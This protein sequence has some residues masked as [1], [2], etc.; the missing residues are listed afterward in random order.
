MTT[1][2]PLTLGTAGHIDH[3][4][5]ALVAA[6]TGG[7]T[8]RLPAEKAR[9]ISIELGYAP[10]RLAS[11]RRLSVVDVP[12]HERF[13][14][15]MVAGATGID[16]YLMVVAADDGVMP[17]TREHAAVLAALGVATGVVAVTKADVAD[18]ARAATRGERAAPRAR[19]SSRARRAPAPASRTCAPPSTRSPTACPG[20]DASAGEP[21][22]HVDRAFTIRGA[23]TVVTGTLWAGAIAPGDRLRPAAGRHAGP[24]ALRPGPRRARR[25]RRRGPA[26]RRQPRRRRAARRRARRRRRRPRSGGALAG[27]RLRA[28]AA[29]RQPRDARPRA[30][31]HAR[32]ARAPGRP[33][34]R[35]CGRRAWSSRCWR[36]PAIASSCARSRLP[37]PSA[38]ASC[39]T[40]PPGATAAATTRSRA[41]SACAAASRSPRPSRP[42]R[43]RRAARGLARA[44]GRLRARARGAPARRR[45][46]AAE[47]RRP[48]GSRPRRSARRRARRARRAARCTRTPRRWRP[49]AP[50]SR[51]SSPPTGRSR[52][53]A[54]ATS[55]RPRASSPRRHLE[56]LD[57]ERVTKRLP[58]DSRVL[59]AAAIKKA[60]AHADHPGGESVLAPRSRPAQGPDPAARG[61]GAPP[62]LD[63]P[64]CVGA[65]RRALRLGAAGRPPA[66]A[67]GRRRAARSRSAPPSPRAARV[68]RRSRAIAVC[69]GL[70]TSSAVVVHLMNGAIE[71]HFHF[72]VMVSVLALYEDWFPYLLA[73]AFVLGHHGLMGVLE[74]AS[75]YNHPDAIAHPWRWAGI[76]ALFI[77]ALGIV[78][79]VHWR[80]N[81]D[82]RADALHSQERFR[83]AFDDAPI[84]MALTG[85]DGVV[86]RA[87]AVLCERV[88]ADPAGLPLAD[89]VDPDDLAGRPFPA[90]ERRD[91]AALPRRSRV[92]AVASLPAH[93]A[94]R[95]SRGLDQPLHRRLQAQARR[96]GA[97]LAGQPRRAHRPA[98]PRALPRAP[99]RRRRAPSGP[100]GRA[101]RRPRRLQGRQR[102]ARSRRGRSPAQRRGRAAVPR[103]APRRRH[104]PLRRRRVHR[105]AA[106][107]RQRGL[108]AA[109]WPSGWPRRCAS[110]SCSTASAATSPPAS[111]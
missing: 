67:R 104:R 28:G 31:R 92:G 103:P 3:G 46:R 75:V 97:L 13:V 107:H 88:G 17:Q 9:G 58:D 59:C 98:Q 64:P 5:T 83:H 2:P 49:S 14:R 94:R 45:P 23:G 102:L 87:N 90:D 6:L 4:K 106:R 62:C 24:R 72:F 35:A 70:L 27:P 30:P 78:N 56:H 25:A 99:Q 68:S 33:R 42:R 32:D 105:P 34:R 20:R 55:F 38:A 73:F 101:P 11:G 7:D 66:V 51:P 85:L 22:L 12:G 43:R 15:T 65:R 71:G 18:P 109:A 95:P 16:L 61:V 108:R 1:A 57:A 100:R 79:V 10:L 76:H 50:G 96:G 93:R 36:A 48:R 86:Q 37:T 8:D 69:V 40:P 41:W 81:E 91:R 47:R 53:R 39:S 74:P 63:A 82:A 111:A 21:L 110:R 84:G 19:R 26:R 52:S 60:G 77:G 29:R 80:L 89:L 44:A 54:C